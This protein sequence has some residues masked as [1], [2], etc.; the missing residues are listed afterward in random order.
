M[1]WK[2]PIRAAL[3]RAGHTLDESI[4]EELALHARAMHESARADGATA[5]EARRRVDQQIAL[6]CDDAAMLRRRH[7][8]TEVHVETPMNASWVAGIG[9][10]LRYGVR[11]FRRQAG[12]TFLVVCTMAL[13]I[14]ATTTLFSLT[15]GVLMKPLPWPAGDRIVL[16][17]ETRGG[18]TPRFG[19]F[20]NAAYLAWREEAATLEG[21]AAWSARTVTL[22]GAGDPQRVRLTTA[23]ASLFPV[24]GV[25]PLIG[26]LFDETHEATG[27]SSVVVLSESLWKQRFGGDPAV[28]GRVVQLDGQPHSITGVLPDGWSYP[29]RQTLAWIPFRVNPATGSSLSM[30]NAIAR[31]RPDATAAQAAAEGTARGRAVPLSTHMDMTVRAI[32]GGDGPLQVSARPLREALTADVR[33]PLVLLLVAVTLLLA[34]ATANVAGLQL[35]RA[36]ARRREMAIRAALGAGTPRVTRQL[37]IESLLTGLTGGAAGLFLAALLHRVMPSMLPTDFPRLE[38]VGVDAVVVIFALVVSVLASVAFGVLP[39]LRARRLNLVESLSEDGTAPS[40]GGSRTRTAR[41]RSAIMAGQVAVACVLLVG[42]SLLGRSFLALVNADR[43]FD[44]ANVLTARLQLPG[45]AYAPERR[46]ELVDAILER[47]RSTPGVT[48]ATYTDGPP[49]GVYGGSAFWINDRQVQAASRTVVPGYFAAMGMRF[50]G[51]RDFTGD[52][53]ASS[54]PV[55]IVNRT[56]ARQYLS[57]SP[58]GERVR[59]W[60]RDKYPHW[61]IIGVVEDVRHRGVTEPLEPEV[62]RYRPA[63]ERRASTSP[64]FIVRTAGDPTAATAT[65]RALA[66]QQDPSLVFDSVMTMEDR[67]RTTLAGP[68]LY[69]MLLGG[70]ASVALAIAGVGLFG[71]LS[72]TV[73]RRSREI[74]VRMALGARQMDIVRLVA[75]QGLM[76]TIGGLAAGLLASAAMAR[77]LA[78][79]LFGVTTHDTVTYVLVPAILI[80]VAVAACLGPARRAATLDPLKVLKSG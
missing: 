13:G 18:H 21:I 42:A 5:E 50:V 58:V 52:D 38:G 44:P 79:L 20:S 80:V 78:A 3:S 31:L 67:V 45:F 34:T 12:F 55:F 33:G 41:L 8:G 10:D 49:L 69:A 39:A 56:F 48:A 51:G 65:L 36:T 54:R 29:D 73:A 70:F 26:T 77:S 2:Q 25:R 28:L 23:T 7:H 59:G 24:L 62:Y 64:T 19:A 22:E 32:F 71:V 16:L 6:W 61:Q 35:A 63:D 40:G 47:L 4:I 76:V 60:V 53:V 11:P 74:A 57:G 30:V 72:Y 15:Y 27:G 66:K 43:G 75:G 14:G 37:L 1:D 9:H 68:R 17:E 46:A